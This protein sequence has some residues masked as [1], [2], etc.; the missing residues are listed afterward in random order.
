ME[1][2]SQFHEEEPRQRSPD[3]DRRRSQGHQGDKLM[4]ET[5]ARKAAGMKFNRGKKENALTPEEK[6]K[7]KK[8][9]VQKKH[10]M[11]VDNLEVMSVHKSIDRANED[12]NVG[13]KALNTGVE[14]AEELAGHL[15][16]QNYSDK[17]EKDI[18][19]NR[20]EIEPE[21][22]SYS[23]HSGKIG[24]NAR[25]ANAKA[26]YDVD[27]ASSQARHAQKEMVKKEMQKAAQ[28]KAREKAAKETAYK[29]EK[30][31]EKV[32]DAVTTF[33]SWVTSVIAEN[34]M[35]LVIA[36]VILVIILLFGSCSASTGTMTG[37][38]SDSTVATSYTADDAEILLVEQ[39]YKDME[40]DLQE[41]VENIETDYPGYD[42]YQYNL[43]EINHNPY[44]LAALLT[45]L[46]EDY[47]EEEVEDKL[48]EI[49]DAQ[50]ELTLTPVT[51]TRTRTETRT[52]LREVVGSDGSITYEEYTYDVEVEYEWKIL[53]VDLTNETMDSV[54]RNM[55]LTEDQMKRYELLL[56]TQGNKPYLFAGDIYATPEPAADDDEYEIPAEMLT[57]QEFANMIREAEKYLDMEY[58]WGGSSPSTGFDCSGFVSYVINHC[59]NG[60]NVGRQTANGLLV[61]CCTRVS[62]ANARPGDLIF[63]KG[64]YNT[65]GASHV[66][67]YV[68]NGMMIHC[69]NPIKYSSIETNYWR[70][71]F[72]TFGRIKD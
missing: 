27:E 1:M 44:Q 45:V 8:L 30:V 26:G 15:A 68:G 63:F 11:Q 3:K 38:L 42:E 64:T 13:T 39:D 62:K 46:Y 61:N 24:T 9:Q 29:T 17:L 22:Q 58:V 14:K 5:S 67:I 20:T 72:Y 57:D 40:E 71:H 65:I 19:K 37:I 69:G 12:D 2:N 34:P 50:Y 25:S 32:E 60:W 33:T 28:K 21:E 23:G 36:L 10:Q 56:E 6:H 48:Q 41:E 7:I 51:E 4:N 66:G 49:F 55:G 31:I 54:V 53:K 52:G 70:N 18:R 59:G 35:I 43:A 47:T 16:Q